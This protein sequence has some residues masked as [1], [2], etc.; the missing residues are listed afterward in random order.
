MRV[1][2][3]RVRHIAEGDYGAWDATIYD[4]DTMVVWCTGTTRDEALTNAREQAA[5]YEQT[6][7]A[8]EWVEL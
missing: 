3:I 1:K 6:E 5:Q 2:L 7:H 8:E 4:G